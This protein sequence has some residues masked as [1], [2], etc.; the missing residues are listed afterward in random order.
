M[1]KV[2]HLKASPPCRLASGSL[3]ILGGC[4]PAKQLYFCLN[5]SLLDVGFWF[6]M[7]FTFRLGGVVIVFWLSGLLCAKYSSSFYEP[8]FEWVANNIKA[9]TVLKW[10][11]SCVEQMIY[12]CQLMELLAPSTP[13]IQKSKLAHRQHHLAQLP[14]GDRLVATPTCLNQTCRRMFLR[15]STLCRITKNIS[16]KVQG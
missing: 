1:V 14:M 15:A 4:L 9:A 8:L 6:A 12:F 11:T 5:I 2:C 13:Y 10:E 3:C 7:P 16:S